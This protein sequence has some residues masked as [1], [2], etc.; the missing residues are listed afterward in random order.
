MK[1]STAI[2]I[3]FRWRS[4]ASAAAAGLFALFWLIYRRAKVRGGGQARFYSYYRPIISSTLPPL[5]I[6]VWQGV[7]R[8]TL[9]TAQSMRKIYNGDAQ[10]Y[11]LHVLLYFLAIYLISETARA[12]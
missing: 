7:E 11:A 6:T 2:G 5:A 4:F 12:L 3:R 10:T 8:S 9:A 1:R